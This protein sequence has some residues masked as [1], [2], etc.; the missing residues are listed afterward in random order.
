MPK[1]RVSAWDINTNTLLTEFKATARTFGQRL[2]DSGEVSME[3][4]L[5]APGE[6]GAVSVLL[7]LNGNPFKLI[8]ATDDSSSILYSGICW[9]TGRGKSSDTL[10]LSG[11]ALMSYFGNTLITRNYV[12]SIS[13]TT[14]LQNVITDVQ[15]QNGAN[16]GIS[17]R[18]QVSIAPP[19]VVPNY[20]QS[21]RTTAA[22]VISDICAAVTPGTGGIDYYMEDA[23]VNGVPTHTFVIA[24]PRAGRVQDPLGAFIDMAAA[25]DFDWPTDA[26]QTGND[27]YVVGGGSGASQPSAHA[28]S[29]D[30]IGGFGQLPLLQ[31]VY[32][33]SQIT[34]TAQLQN[35]AAGEIRLYGKPIV[36][37]TVTLPVDYGPLPLGSF[38]VGDDVRVFSEPSRWFPKGLDE[39]WR[40]VA[41]TADLPD[42]GVSTYKLTLNRPPVF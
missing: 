26:Q 38:D 8:V 36:T 37:P 21:Q 4:P 5:E 41:Y 33:Y 30:P 17:S 13:P 7:G 19:N 1:F 32:Q 3:A 42:E 12:T 25:T 16:L 35:I 20:K 18:L 15:A 28:V 11:K 2:S 23:F 34:K 40:I 27:I 6:H 22:Q 31:Q 14:L 9:Q 10:K 24:A 39:W 29:N